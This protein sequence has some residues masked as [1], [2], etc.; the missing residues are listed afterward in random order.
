[1]LLACDLHYGK[2]LLE[3]SPGIISAS[4]QRGNLFRIVLHLDDPSRT[5]LFLAIFPERELKGKRRGG[6]TPIRE[7]DQLVGG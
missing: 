3:L 7:H 5:F 4:S 1:M 2:A 6:A